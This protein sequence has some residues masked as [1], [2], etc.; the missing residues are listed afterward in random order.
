M[1]LTLCLCA[2]AAEGS[3]ND[4]L[5][6]KQCYNVTRVSVKVICKNLAERCKRILLCLTQ[7]CKHYCRCHLL[8]FFILH[9]QH[10][11]HATSRNVLEVIVDPTST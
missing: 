1:T 8:H 6:H 10:N 4:T 9:L 3:P 7:H 11:N 2:V 5:W